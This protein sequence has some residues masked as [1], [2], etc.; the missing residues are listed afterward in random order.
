MKKDQ[1]QHDQVLYQSYGQHLS[2][3][4]PEYLKRLGIEA[5]AAHAEG[6]T[7]TD[8]NGKSYIDCTAGYGLFNLGHNHPE[9]V[10]A[11]VDQLLSAQPMTRPLISGV[12]VEMGERL[13]AVSPG[14]M[15]CV[16][17]CNSGSE[18]VDNAIK[19]ARLHTRKS[20]IIAAE[21]SFHGYTYGALSATG[22]PKFK[23][24]FGPLLSDVVHV[25][26]G[27]INALKSAIT[28][29]TAAVLLEPMQHE[30]GIHIPPHDYLAD[31]RALCSDKGVLLILDEVKT[32]F[33]K[34]GS[35]FAC[36]DLGLIPDILVLGKSL[37]GG[38]IPSGAII[39][40]QA[41]WR[42]FSLSFSMSASS[43]AGNALAS[44]AA[45]TTLDIF[46]RD[47]SIFNCRAKGESLMSHLSTLVARFPNLL[48]RVS[49]KGLLIGL[50]TADP[51]IAFNLSC[52]LT[53]RGVLAM[54][55]FGEGAEIM[56]E[57]PLVISEDQISE[58]SGAID[59]AC[60]MLSS[61][62]RK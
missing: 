9:L 55:A 30:A 43:F 38:L 24:F 60:H 15:D 46:Q 54:Q 3:S 18:A 17:L 50:R 34:A 27:D 22:I 42:K 56:F 62:A 16:F 23:K 57:P 47:G 11:L 14:D 21:G 20:R 48:T 32:G 33:G 36:D 51:R 13:A 8:S 41:I 6:A 29:E 12:Q 10:Q 2:H 5:T 59:E 39:S 35:L 7:I 44:R 31:V 53:E 58:V 25:P 19:L 49:G 4:Y 45:I 40:T 37:G 1:S 52:L 26:Y 28:P 61:L